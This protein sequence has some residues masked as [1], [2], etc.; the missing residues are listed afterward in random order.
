MLTNLF[1]ALIVA[2]EPQGRVEEVFRTHEPCAMKVEE[3]RRQ[4]IVAACVPTTFDDLEQS[5]AQMQALATI[6]HDN[7]DRTSR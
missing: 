7:S 2:G 6:Y 5:R 3:Y 1:F 4:Y